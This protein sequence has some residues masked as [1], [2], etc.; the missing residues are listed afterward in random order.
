MSFIRWKIEKCPLPSAPPAFNTAI[1][2]HGFKQHPVRSPRIFLLIHH[3]Y[4]VPNLQSQ[5]CPGYHLIILPW[6]VKI[7]LSK[8][9]SLS[10]SSWKFYSTLS[11]ISMNGIIFSLVMQTRNQRHLPFSVFFT[12]NISLYLN[13][14][15]FII[16]V[17][18]KCILWP[19]STTS[20]LCRLLYFWTM[21]TTRPSNCIF[22]LHCV[23]CCFGFFF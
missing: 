1:Y 2:F 11:S 20:I 3:C 12:Q 22:L 8:L 9:K 16:N 19:I 13:L 6:Q 5:L 7:H 21:L 15:D 4:W 23:C 18:L 10:P 17:F 14:A